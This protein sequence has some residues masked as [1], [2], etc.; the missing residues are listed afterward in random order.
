MRPQDGMQGLC[1]APLLPPNKGTATTR[2][3]KLWYAN[4]GWSIQDQSASSAFVSNR[5]LGTCQHH[6]SDHR[7]RD[8][9]RPLII[10][11]QNCI[12][13][14]HTSGRRHHNWRQLP[15]QKG[16]V[17]KSEYGHLTHPAIVNVRNWTLYQLAQVMI[18]ESKCNL[19]HFH[20]KGVDDFKSWCEHPHHSK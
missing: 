10:P 18:T 4:N 19:N 11:P 8:E 15:V 5:W 20:K 3:R 2:L 9:T 12:T 1:L 16:H 17:D 14:A 6:N 13:L 7:Q